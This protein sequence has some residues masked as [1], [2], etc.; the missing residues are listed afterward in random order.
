MNMI[1]KYLIK[2]IAK[3][4]DENRKKNELNTYLAAKNISAE[5][6]ADIACDAKAQYDKAREEME[7][8]KRRYEILISK[9]KVD[10]NEFDK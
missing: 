6:I 5:R 2:R 4:E 1:N 10:K 3:L 9:C 7:V 8:L